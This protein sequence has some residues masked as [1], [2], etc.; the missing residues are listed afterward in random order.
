MKRV[1]VTGASG[2]I[3]RELCHALRSKGVLVRALLR[4]ETEGPYDQVVIGD[5][6][7]G[8]SESLVENVDT[9]IHLAG[10]AH[11]LHENLQDGSEYH[12]VNTEGTRTLLEFANKSGVHAFIY[13][14]SVL[15][16]GESDEVVDESF[17]VP[18]TSP[19]GISKRD[20]E[21]LVLA[22]GYVPHPVVI[23]P[24]M[25][26]GNTTKGNLPR[27]IRAIQS[28]IFPSLPDVRNS[29][30]MVHVEDVVQAII[31]AAESSDATEKVYIVTDGNSYS[32]RQIY[33]WICEGLHKPVSGWY[34]PLFVLRLLGKIGDII[35]LLRGRR[36]IFS[37]DALEKLIGNAS[38]S[39]QR[40]QDDLGFK[41]TRNL[42]ESL[43][44]I[45]AF[46]QVNRS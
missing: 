15:A 22:G 3:G 34:F 26:Y 13:I 40:I 30:S 24:S 21:S 37:S 39:S 6:T 42:R 35:G 33:E 27:M 31:L 1:L 32:T 9:V 29:R 7:K 5:L 43:P 36:F 38:Y 8:V 44:E 4:S 10:I 19:Y 12:R 20:A 2:F 25:V 45:I 17:S 18:P 23:R 28:G 14:S 16:V 41:P 46:L 11:A